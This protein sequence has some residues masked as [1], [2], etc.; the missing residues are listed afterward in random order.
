MRFKNIKISTGLFI[1]FLLFFIMITYVCGYSLYSAERNHGSLSAASDIAN[2][3][4]HIS[5]IRANLFLAFMDIYYLTENSGLTDSEINKRFL[6]INKNMEAGESKLTEFM[7][8]PFESEK[9]KAIGY[10]IADLYKLNHKLLKEAEAE[11]RSTHFIKDSAAREAARSNFSS[12]A[13]E[14]MQANIKRSAVAKERAQRDKKTSL[15]IGFL[16]LTISFGQLLLT[17]MWVRKQIVMRLSA[18]TTHLGEIGRGELT[19]E[20]DPGTS[21]EIGKL[22]R[23]VTSMQNNLVALIA[24][25][26]RSAEV[27]ITGA[28]EISVGN[29]DLS[30]RTEQQAAALEETAASMEEFTATVKQNAESASQARELAMNASQIAQ[31]GGKVVDNVVHTMKGIAD[32]SQKIADITNVIDGIAF[33]TNIL[34]LNAAVEAARAG[35]QGRGF[36]VVASEVRN[37]AQR[38]AQA[39]KEIKGLITDSVSKVKTGSEQVETAGETMNDIVGAVAHVTD[40]MNEIASASDEQSRGID[41]V[42]Q[43]VSEMDLVTQQN[44]SLVEESATA[45]TALETHASHLM[46][47]VS[48]FHI[49]EENKQKSVRQSQ[50]LKQGTTTG[51]DLKQNQSPTDTDNNANMEWTSF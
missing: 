14:Y 12:T 21:N 35:E 23:G 48:A 49:N 9:T 5:G 41:Q 36:A 3:A 44:A 7:A 25:V 43:A 22:I 19:A 34:A 47:A 20:L 29:N 38:S 39:A 50:T 17:W 33:Q 28:S 13:E 42:A 32:S 16:S 6:A 51:P 26:R 10:R 1:A 37:L 2:D 46:D 40:I 18:V 27:I 45:A 24:G 8:I 15:I 11:A 30:S 31:R 4:S